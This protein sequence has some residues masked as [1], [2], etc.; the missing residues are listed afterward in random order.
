MGVGREGVYYTLH[1]TDDKIEAQRLSKGFKTSQRPS[2]DFVAVQSHLPNAPSAPWPPPAPSLV[3]LLRV[4]DPSARPGPHTTF[5]SLE[6]HLRFLHGGCGP[7]SRTGT[8]SLGWRQLPKPS[9]GNWGTAF[10][11]FRY[12]LACPPRSLVYPDRRRAV[13]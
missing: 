5:L 12:S 6:L 7:I 1:S 11:Q 9:L 8:G 4:P 3:A 10:L 2:R 13:S